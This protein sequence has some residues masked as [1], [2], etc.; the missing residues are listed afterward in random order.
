M[1]KTFAI[2]GYL[3]GISYLVLFFN[4][5]IIKNIDME[6]YKNLLFPI[7]ITHGFLF[8]A[9][10]ILAIMLKVELNWSFKK[11]LLIFIASLIPFGTFYSDRNWLH[12]K[13]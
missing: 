1:L 4:M 12:K 5:L 3:E 2:T 10:F 6:L 9:Y 7:G 13:I 8:I 11:F